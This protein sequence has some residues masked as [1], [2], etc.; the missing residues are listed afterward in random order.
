VLNPLSIIHRSEGVVI[1]FGK[2]SKSKNLESKEI[3]KIIIKN[4]SMI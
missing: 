4:N 3:K 1:G 2:I